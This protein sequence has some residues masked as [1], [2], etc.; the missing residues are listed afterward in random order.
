VLSTLYMYIL[1]AT[2]CLMTTSLS[3]RM[4]WNSE[5]TWRESNHTTPIAW[6]TFLPP[7]PKVVYEMIILKL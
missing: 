4:N 1:G 3:V 6:V 7:P 5:D 2:T